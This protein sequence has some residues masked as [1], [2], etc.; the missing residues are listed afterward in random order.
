M[1]FKE[2]REQS[3]MGLKQFSEYF[4]IP[5]RT[6]QNWN[7]GITA[8]PEY[9]MSL[10]TYKLSNEGVITDNTTPT[11]KAE[12]ESAIR[13]KVRVDGDITQYAAAFLAIY[14]NVKSDKDL[15]KVYNDYENGVYVICKSEV[16]DAAV[17]FLEQFGVVTKIELIDAYK[18]YVQNFTYP[19]YTDV[20]F[21]DVEE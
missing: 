10:F 15:Y 18:S 5:Y 9:M 4:D 14:N 7:A 8:C 21:L 2:L 1:T 12:K 6:I 11:I 17:K 3:G 19:E 20:E 16:R 13:I